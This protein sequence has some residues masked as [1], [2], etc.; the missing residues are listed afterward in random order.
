MNTAN[1]EFPINYTKEAFLH[2]ANLVPLLVAITTICG[3]VISDVGIAADLALTMI[4]AAELMYLGIVPRLPRF[5]KVVKLRKIRE[6]D[7]EGEEKELFKSLSEKS[8]RQYLVLRHLVKLIENNFEKLPY[9]SQGLL[10]N[11]RK[12]M[13]ELLYNYLTLLDLYKRY[14]LYMNTS[15]EERLEEEVKEEEQHIRAL[16]SVQL[17]K[18]KARRVRILKKRLKK[19]EIAKEKYLI[20]ETHLETIEDAIRYIYEQSM[21]MSNPEEI[22]FQLDNLLEEMEETSSLIDDLDQN[23]FSVHEDL[24]EVVLDAELK[25]AE[26]QQN[27]ATSKRIKN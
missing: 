26:S 21:T 5:R 23:T 24:D 11:I 12:K 9:S 18:T 4:C 6:K 7:A 13:K 15:V 19:F 16:E 27:K 14:Q 25:E 10:E 1:S 20:C 17:K 2:P 3:L 8:K 22:G